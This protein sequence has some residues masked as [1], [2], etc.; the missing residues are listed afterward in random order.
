[1]DSNGL[2]PA[3]PSEDIPAPDARQLERA[4]A[5]I[6]KGSAIAVTGA[7]VSAESGIPTFRDPGGF[8][9]KYPPEEYAAYS[10]FLRDPKKV[11]K[12]WQER[13]AMLEQA[14]PNDA[15]TGLAALEEMR[16]LQAVITQ[17]VDNLHQEA[18]SRRVIEYHGNARQMVCL[19]CGR[20]EP[21]TRSRIQEIP[22]KCRSC[23]GLMKPGVVMFEEFIPEDALAESERLA[24]G[25]NSMLVAGTSA[26]VYPAASLP[27]I[28]KYNGA[29]IIEIN[30]EPT[31]FTH[32]LVDV[33]LQGSAGSVIRRL[34][35]HLKAGS[36]G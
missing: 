9:R 24:M 22:P 25:C 13:A 30:V 18:G 1:M 35:E 26:Q 17:N 34:T 2:K 3:G 19:E 14:R 31:D 33:F 10:A 32:D 6:R 7:G 15:H 16:Y 36:S 21:L 11:W 5:A 20:S 12:M 23:G 27:Q 4:A 29:T 8:W 28:A